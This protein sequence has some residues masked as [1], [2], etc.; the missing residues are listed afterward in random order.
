MDQLLEK[1][2][3]IDICLTAW[4]FKS[5]IFYEQFNPTR[6]FSKDW[7]WIALGIK[8]KPVERETSQI[9]VPVKISSSMGSIFEYL[10]YCFSCRIT[11]FASI[12][13]IFLPENS[14]S[15]FSKKLPSGLCF[16]LS[17]FSRWARFLQLFFALAAVLWL[18]RFFFSFSWLFWMIWIIEGI[19][20][21]GF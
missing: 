19:R 16:A 6:T 15:W 4:I 21:D 11:V 12:F 1:R 14:L 5:R 7:G 3:V 18:R 13:P 20:K 10:W 8:I 9:I 17:I 2:P